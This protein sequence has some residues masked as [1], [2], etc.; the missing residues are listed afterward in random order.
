M[1]KKT[2][3][4]ILPSGLYLPLMLA[5]AVFSQPPVSP[6]TTVK[7]VEIHPKDTS[8]SLDKMVITAT[9]TPRSI[10]E[11]PAVVTVITK[12]QIEASP[13]KTISDILLYEP[14]IVV[15]RPS[16][17]GEGIP[18]GINIRGVPTA[19]AATRTLILMDGIPTNAVGTP[20]LLLNE[21]PMEAIERI[22][23]VRGPYSN[24]YGANA[25]GGVI[26]VITKSATP[27]FHGD[28]YGGIGYSV[29]REIGA[30][31]TLASGKFSYVVNGMYRGT[32][33]YLY[34]DSTL[35]RNGNKEYI[36]PVENRGYDEERVIAK[37][38]YAFNS[39]TNLTLQSRFFKS[40]LQFGQT[41]HPGSTGMEP[42]GIVRSTEG[43][44]FLIGPS[45]K[46]NVSDV[47]DVKFGGYFRTLSGK[48]FDQGYTRTLPQDTVAS[49]WDASSNDGELDGQALLR[50]SEHQ[51]LTAGY[52]V[53]FNSVDFGA[54]LD[55]NTG[56]TLLGSYATSKSITN[57]GFYIQD[58]L[59]YFSRLVLVAGARVDRHS[60]FGI[61]LS[62]RIGASYKLL[63]NLRLRSSAGRAYRAPNL[64]ELYM[65]DL[66]LGFGKVIAPNPALKPEYIWTVDGGAESDLA[67]WVT[68]HVDG[69]YNRM[70]DLIKPIL[71]T[72]Y[73]SDT[74]P[75]GGAKVSQ[76]NGG[77][78]ISAGMET[79]VSVK[80]KQWLAIFTNYTYTWSKDLKTKSSLDFIPKHALNVGI[81]GKKDFGKVTL[82]GS[83]DGQII[84]S[85]SYLDVENP[86][87]NLTNPENST[88]P[89]L[90]PTSYSRADLSA[91]I[92]YI[93]KIW[94][95]LDVQNVFNQKIEEAAGSL[96]PGR[97]ISARIGYKF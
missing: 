71:D 32:N 63:D 35:Y 20:F 65:P 18:A 36:R 66:M 62:P 7:S 22:E 1:K 78:A 30:I 57:V 61:A 15:Q 3:R 11:M 93:S 25:L 27:G 28:I 55:K 47:L 51:S 72:I 82:E 70:D 92:W 48:Y 14:G 17:M 39:R 54:N 85:R 86:I 10:K 49:V 60:V 91:R 73:T 44:K 89:S 4:I 50:L 43:G 29:L 38:G 67:K 16:G 52:D 42:T 79:G 2:K 84:N 74:V 31:N 58:E 6:D 56:D 53:L 80:V 68:V 24:L 26:N 83:I 40:N 87:P 90:Y 88:W 9:R 75:E 12:E 45:L 76:I 69:F 94:F 19:L 46:I 95:A 64:T 21:I 81:M 97:L 13:A 34:K 23:V 77:N 96:A 33:N 5:F 59:K 37:V 8:V 41:W